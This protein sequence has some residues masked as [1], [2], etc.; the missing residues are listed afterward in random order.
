ME[1]HPNYRATTVT[2]SDKRKFAP[3]PLAFSKR[4]KIASTAMKI[5]YYSCDVMCLPQKWCSD[6][7]HI[8]IPRGERRN[9]PGA[10]GLIGQIKFNSSM[11]A[12]VISEEICKVFAN[13]MDLT[14]AEIESGQIFPFTYLL[15]TGAGSRTL[16][17]PVVL[18]TFE[19]S[20]RQFS[21]LATSGG[22]IYI[23]AEA[24]LSCF[25]PV[26]S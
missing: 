1:N 26:S 14:V 22:M 9:L 24:T 6:P 23:M 20:G 13:P 25:D 17:I 3:P 5:S 7:G 11:S 8:T 4:R 12:Q 21:T 18:E 19:W 15:R 16:R 2:R 10:R